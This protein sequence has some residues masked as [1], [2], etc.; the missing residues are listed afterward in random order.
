M[1]MKGRTVYFSDTNQKGYG[2]F[3]SQLTTT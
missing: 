1:H 3:N 2:H